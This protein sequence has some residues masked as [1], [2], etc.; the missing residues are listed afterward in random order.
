MMHKIVGWQNDDGS[1]SASTFIYHNIY[2]SSSTQPFVRGMHRKS[3]DIHN[4][5]VGIT[6]HSHTHALDKKIA[7]MRRIGGYAMWKWHQA[8]LLLK[9][10]R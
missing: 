1:G 3:Y 8:P 9:Y 7:K 5:H 2:C 4:D 10:L 6:A